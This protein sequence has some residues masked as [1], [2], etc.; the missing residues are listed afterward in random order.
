MGWAWPL[1]KCELRSGSI[2]CNQHSLKKIPAHGLA[3][4]VGLILEADLAV[5]SKY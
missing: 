2:F 3:G 5:V 4:E 1:G